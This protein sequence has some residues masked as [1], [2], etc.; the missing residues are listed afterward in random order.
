MSVRPLTGVRLLDLSRVVAG[1]TCCFWL[2]ALGAEVIRIESP[3]GDIGWQTYP[4]VGPDGEHYGPLRERDI[5]LSPLRKNR[6][7]RS[8]VLDLQTP[9]GRDVLLQL[10]AHSDVLIENFKPGSMASWGLDWPT[11]EATNPRLIYATITGYG[12]HGPYR[13]KPAMDPI[14]QAVSGLMARTGQRDGPP[15]RVAATIGDQ[16]P[17]MWVAVGVLA[18]LRQRELDGRG[19]AIDVAML[20]ALVAL[21]WDDPL[22][23]YEDQ[24]IPERFGS[25]DPRG[26]PFGVYQSAD[27]WVALAAPSDPMWARLAPIVGGAALDERWTI[28]RERAVHQDELNEVIEAWTRARSTDE[29]VDELERHGVPVG[30]VNPPWW[31]RHDP[32]I[33][34][35]GT[36][37][38]LRHPDLD[39]PTT[40]LGPALPIRFT[41]A[42]I[43]TAPAEPLGAS[44]DAVMRE[45]LGL[46]DT[47]IEALREKGAFGPVTERC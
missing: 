5:P 38:R 37:E 45:L 34:Q 8:V 22:D 35:R 44:T 36:L 12:W 10:V 19:Q 1:P 2:A 28:H 40:W 46:D 14:V 9:A 17:G 16:L 26:G 39:Q 24:G 7:K 23:L 25:G 18:A 33:E 13:D 32:H 42:A 20:D 11:L 15:T 4:R 6:G 29:I 43:D 30:R 41:R 3:G 47:T 31:A 27:S 21:S